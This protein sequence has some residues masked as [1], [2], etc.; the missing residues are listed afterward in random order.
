VTVA[1]PLLGA[2]A[3]GA[4]AS[5]AAA[6]GAAAV[7]AWAAAAEAAEA[8]EAA[9]SATASAREIGAARRQPVV[10]RFGCTDRCAAEL[11][12]EAFREQGLAVVSE[13]LARIDF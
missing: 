2:G 9:A 3:R 10:V 1:F 13:E 8:A 5:E 4:P 7:S 6:V 12:E 11:L